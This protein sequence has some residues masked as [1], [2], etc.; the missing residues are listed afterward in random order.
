[1]EKVDISPN[2]KISKRKRERELGWS[3]LAQHKHRSGLSK[4]SIIDTT[5]F[6][7]FSEAWEVLD[8][9]VYILDFRLV[10]NRSTH[11]TMAA[12]ENC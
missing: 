3:E 6:S 7:H 5:A 2:V 10:K 8:N 4:K 9:K 12:L 1:M 11:L